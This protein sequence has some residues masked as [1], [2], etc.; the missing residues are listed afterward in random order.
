MRYVVA[1]PGANQESD[2]QRLAAFEEGH[3][4]PLYGGDGSV[5]GQAHVFG[6]RLVLSASHPPYQVWSH[7]LI[8]GHTAALSEAL[9][10]AKRL[11]F[12]FGLL[13]ERRNEDEA[14]DGGSESRDAGAGTGRS[15]D[16]G[17][18]AQ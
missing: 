2:W 7:A 10:E 11:G 13:A 3:S 9:R 15:R 4:V 1:Y 5:V 18:E 8:L 17:G 16:P 12:E 6:G 14:K